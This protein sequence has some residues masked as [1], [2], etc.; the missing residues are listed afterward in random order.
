MTKH[1]RI[2]VR[3][4]Y[5]LTIKQFVTFLLGLTCAL[6]AISL[7]DELDDVLND[8]LTY[9]LEKRTEA[10]QSPFSNA[11]SPQDVQ[12]KSGVKSDSK[13]TKGAAQKAFKSSDDDSI[14]AT[15]TKK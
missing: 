4:S 10:A 14:K 3:G 2:S 15:A 1:Y 11:G 9:R 13:S 5:A 12:A 7:A 6:P 8:L